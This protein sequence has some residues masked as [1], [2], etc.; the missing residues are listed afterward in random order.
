MFLTKKYD[1]IQK[2]KIGNVN[3][4]QLTGNCLILSIFEIILNFKDNM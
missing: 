1:K 3:F 2:L 4:Y